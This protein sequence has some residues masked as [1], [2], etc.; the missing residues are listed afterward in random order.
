MKAALTTSECVYSKFNEIE[1]VEKFTKD[2]K[3]QHPNVSLRKSDLWVLDWTKKGYVRG[4][5]YVLKNV[6]EDDLKIIRNVLNQ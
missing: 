5:Y 6:S 3:E 1:D 2:V 4:S